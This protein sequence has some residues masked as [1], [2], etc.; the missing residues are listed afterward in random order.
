MAGLS[1]YLQPSVYAGV[2]LAAGAIAQDS[3]LPAAS[4]S[5]AG[6]APGRHCPPMAYKQQ[7]KAQN[8]KKPLEKETPPVV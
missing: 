2:L 3:F 5:P 7:I 4:F 6:M 1:Q 8:T